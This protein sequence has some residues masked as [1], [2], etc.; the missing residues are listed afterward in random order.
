VIFTKLH[1]PAIK[2]LRYN[3]QT[4]LHRQER[5]A[6]KISLLTGLPA[7][8]CHWLNSWWYVSDIITVM[9]CCLIW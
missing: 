3:H 8:L 5:H 4:S 1:Q 6:H 7:S 2:D 9:P